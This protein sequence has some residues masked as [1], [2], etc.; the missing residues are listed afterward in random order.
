MGES[1]D[2]DEARGIK[3]GSCRYGGRARKAGSLTPGGLVWCSGSRRPSFWTGGRDGGCREMVVD[4]QE[5][6]EVIVEA[7]IVFVLK[8]RT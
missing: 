7:E 6:A 3:T 2:S 4:G 8:D 1:A 5:S